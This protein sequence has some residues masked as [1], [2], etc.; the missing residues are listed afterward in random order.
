MAKNKIRVIMSGAYGRMGRAVTA[1]VTAEPD[2][3]V[4]GALDMFGV[5]EDAGEAAGIKSLGVP[6][7]NDLKGLLKSTPA[8]VMVDFTIADKF[9]PRAKAALDA[10]L[11]LVVGTTAVPAA[12]LKRIEKIA[13]QKKRAVIVAPNF[14]MGAV[15]M[16][17]FAAMAAPYM[18]EAEIIELHHD[19]KRD[20]PS[21]TALYTAELMADAKKGLPRR[22]D[23]TEDEK[24]AGARGGA[25]GDISV[26]SVRLPGF[27]AHQEVIFGGP[28]QTLTLR[29]DTT[30][31]ESFM[32][33]VVL[34]VRK[35]M[36]LRKYV[37]GLDK[38]I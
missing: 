28:G 19:K 36:D 22:K 4:V 31:R 11:R 5:G 33:G 20:A 24:L 14:A 16:M 32:P 37:F 30:S 26:H 3:Q 38:L 7:T 2:M 13:T 27:L 15:L 34:A 8:D 9:Y 10:G 25:L 6:I 21:G 29:H 35:S 18:P 17:K 23:P 12:T 1:A